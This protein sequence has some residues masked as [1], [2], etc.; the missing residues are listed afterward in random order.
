M[1]E[2][3]PVRQHSSVLKIFFVFFP[4]WITSFGRCLAEVRFR[5][6]PN[7]FSYSSPIT[8]TK[9][10]NVSLS[11][12]WVLSERFLT[13]SLHETIRHASSFPLNRSWGIVNLPNTCFSRYTS[14]TCLSTLTHDPTIIHFHFDL[15]PGRYVIFYQISTMVNP[16]TTLLSSAL[17]H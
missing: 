11:S 12:P 3:K 5:R 17:L 6:R 9:D 15:D 8:R 2:N 7:A 10:G 4:K 16:R 13:P 1:V 14:R